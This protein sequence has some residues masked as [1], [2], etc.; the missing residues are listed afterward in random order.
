MMSPTRGRPKSSAQGEVQN[1]PLGPA[2][3]DAG[4]PHGNASREEKKH[5]HILDQK[6]AMAQDEAT[7]LMEMGNDKLDLESD[8]VKGGPVPTDIQLPPHQEE[9]IEEAD[10]QVAYSSNEGDEDE[11]GTPREGDQKKKRKRD[12]KYDEKHPK[13]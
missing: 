11:D 4:P 1:L 13:D 6:P 9:E 2:S 3:R 8:I 5:E 12:A 10:D 7:N